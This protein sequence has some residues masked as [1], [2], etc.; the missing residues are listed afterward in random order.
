MCS[1]AAGQS[2]IQPNAVVERVAQGF[3]FVEGPVW[4]DGALFFSDIPGNKIYRW[5]P[6]SGAEIFLEPS[7]NSNGLALDQEGSLLLAQHGLRQIARLDAGNT[8]TPLATEFDGLSL[9]SPND[10]TLHSDSS[11]YF[12]DPPWGISPGQQELSF[13]GVFRIAPDGNL[14]LLVDSLFKPNGIVFSPDES[15]LYVS[16]SDQRTVV[17]YDVAN[18]EL[19]NGRLFATVSGSGAAD[20]M[21]TD[22][23]G[24]LYVTSPTGVDIYSK[25]GLLLDQVVVP[26]QT[27]NLAWG[28]SDGKTLYITSGTSIYRL[29]LGSNTG[30]NQDA[31]GDSNEIEIENYP[32]P[33]SGESTIRYSLPEAGSVRLVLTDLQGRT[34][35][36][37]DEGVRLAGPHEVI[38]NTD[39]LPASQY[40]YRIE[41]AAS[42]TT[43]SFVQVR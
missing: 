37:V 1:S 27:T 35:L 24:R 25:E 12:T 32:N 3:Q 22:D 28:D 20:G 26:E 19:S 10:L 40:F 6:G 21:K 17:A 4:K 41:S 23:Q 18:H 43:G 13:W 9:N 5:T 8:L 38:L 2:P 33:T 11:I 15:T 29:R 31:G 34:R 36:V 16:T 30:L 39:Y 7:G 14:H 42:S